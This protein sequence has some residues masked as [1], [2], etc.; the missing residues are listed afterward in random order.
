MTKTDNGDMKAYFKKLEEAENPEPQEAPD[1]DQKGLCRECLE[2][3][4]LRGETW[5]PNHKDGATNKKCPNSG[6]SPHGY[7][8]V[9]HT[10][11]EAKATALYLSNTSDRHRHNIACG[12]GDRCHADHRR[13]AQALAFYVLGFR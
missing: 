7:R 1:L 10:A 11:K 2:W 4:D 3:I 8:Y 5:L 13:Y 12:D 6:Y 9:I